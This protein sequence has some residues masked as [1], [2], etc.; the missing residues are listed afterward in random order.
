MGRKV[1]VAVSTLNQW[2]LDFQGNLSRI[3]QSI[4]EAKEMGATYRT[5]PELEIC[6]YSCEDHFLEPDTFLHS[7]EVLLEL[8]TSTFCQNILVDV[9]MPIQHRNVSYN[10]RVVFFNRKILLIRPKMQNCDDGCYRE[11]RWFSMWKKAYTTEDF[12]L[13]RMISAVT[14]QQTVPIGDAVIATKD[15]CIGYEICEELWNPKSTHIDMS[16]SGVEIIVNSS[17][18]Y[19]QLRKAY[20]TTDLI[21]NATYKAGGAYLF[22]NLR[23]CDGQRVYFNGCSAVALNGEIIARGKQFSLQE[24]EITLATIDLEDIRSYRMALRSRSV[25]AASAPTYLRINVDFEMSSHNCMSI[26]TSVPLQWKYHSPEEEIALGP[27]CWLWDYLRRSGQ[28]GFFLP[29]SGGVD[30]S[31]TAAIVHSMCRLVVNSIEHGD[32]QVVH[33]VRKILGDPEYTP[34]NPHALCNRL[35]VTCYMGSENSSAETKQ[36]ASVLADQLGSYHLDINIDGAVSA[37]IGVF[38]FVTG[39]T[40]KFRTEGGCPRQN[41]ALQNIQARI[42]M[43]LAYLFAQ[44]MLWVRNRPG[45]LLVLGS[46]N[47][48]EALRGYMTKYDCSSADINPIGGISKADLRKF[49]LYVRHQF[50]LPIIDEIVTAPPTAELEPLVSGQLAQT[51]EQDMGMTYAELSEYGRL[52]KQAYCGPFSMFCKLVATWGNACTPGEVAEKV[53]HFFRCY[54]INRHKMTVLTPSYH[55][56]SY[57]PDDNRFDHRPFLYRANWSWQFKAID[58]ELE[59]ILAHNVQNPNIPSSNPEQ[60]RDSNQSTKQNISRKSSHRD[61]KHD[62]STSLD[63]KH[64][65]S[66]TKLNVNVMG[67]IRDRSGIPVDML[68]KSTQN[69]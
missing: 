36:R 39:M 55:A 28:G 7:W 31:S 20:V 9:G 66:H 60:S 12:Y 51:D 5:G 43:V 2:A 8:I 37:L 29:L 3:L 62:S 42:R 35:L 4:V 22:S 56:E 24:V 26:P 67:K 33:D 61:S 25:L 53:K 30:S 52:R 65:S 46:A 19:M 47:V 40:P 68:Q 11:T 50:N 49:L 38:T 54:A 45:G 58:E 27:A 14:G 6:G 32:I 41:L 21:R 34:D 10:C 16:L 18:S 48:D 63:N 17:G 23:G 15:T 59:R 69:I 64:R 13:P 1:T 44:L 57:S